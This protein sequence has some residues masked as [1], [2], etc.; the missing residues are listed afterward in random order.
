[1]ENHLQRRA[2][3]KLLFAI[4]CST[5]AGLF[6]QTAGDVRNS[7]WNGTTFASGTWTGTGVAGVGTNPPQ[8]IAISGTGALV[9]DI[10]QTGT[11][12]TPGSLSP[13]SMTWTQTRRFPKYMHPIDPGLG[14]YFENFEGG[15]GDFFGKAYTITNGV[16]FTDAN[17]TRQFDNARWKW[18]IPYLFAGTQI[19]AM[20]GSATT[21]EVFVG[22]KSDSTSLQVS[23]FYSRISGNCSIFVHNGTSPTTNIDPISL[24]LTAP[25]KIGLM[26]QGHY[27]SVWVD[28]GFGWTVRSQANLLT[29]SVDPRTPATLALLSPHMATNCVTGVYQIDAAFGGYAGGLGVAN[30]KRITYEDGTPFIRNNKLYCAASSPFPS[31]TTSP[32]DEIQSSCF[33]IYTVDLTTYELQSVSKVNTLRSGTLYGENSGCIVYDRNSRTF[34]LGIPTWGSY[35]DANADV[36]I[37]VYT[38]QDNILNGVHVLGNGTDLALPSETM[39]YDPDFLKV[40][41]LWY[42][43]YTKTDNIIG[44]NSFPAMTSGTSPL[45]QTTQVGVDTTKT[46][47]N[48]GGTFVHVSGSNYAAFGKQPTTIYIYSMAMVE[49]GTSTGA[50]SNG[51]AVNHPN[52]LPVTT[53]GTTKYVWP[54]FDN[55]AFQSKN[56][57]WGSFVVQEANQ[58]TVGREFNIMRLPFD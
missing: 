45:S 14:Q 39:D 34:Y 35:I 57:S 41:N 49:L 38:T 51:A 22:V 46:G 56:Y 19:K 47:Y 15:I 26:I 24:N 31:P 4:Y 5:I 29:Y 10:L 7:Y 37:F 40:G 50:V 30:L 1:M 8:T 17:G 58:T 2:V 54:G 25:F 6:A 44:S 18:K 12:G 11:F 20:A 36:S 55:T 33:S 53:S 42:M 13:T 43:C 3:K 21:D 32:Y 52:W 27:A 16:L 48:E 23:A 28:E 9:T